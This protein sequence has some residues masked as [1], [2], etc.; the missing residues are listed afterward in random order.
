MFAYPRFIK[1]TTI[2]LLLSASAFAI[3]A[4]AADAASPAP[5]AP[6]HMHRMHHEWNMKEHMEQRIKMLHDTIKVTPEQE[7][8]W[9]DV[10]QVM[11]DNE[12]KMSEMMTTG[13]GKMDNATAIDE[14]KS[15]QSMTQTHADCMA[16]FN[17]AFES[18]YNDL[19][20][21]QKSKADAFFKDMPEHG[22]GKH[23]GMP[24]MA[25]HKKAVAAP[26]VKVK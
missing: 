2:A 26:V 3:P 7:S 21:E 24:H 4:F 14:L 9:A 10:V 18:F 23:H 20:P 19:T 5:K 15:M 11:H 25:H 17:D 6:H 1:Y 16:K 12:A 22:M 13:H 8:N